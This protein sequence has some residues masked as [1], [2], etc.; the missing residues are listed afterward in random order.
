MDYERGLR[1]LHQAGLPREEQELLGSTETTRA[2]RQQI[3]LGLNGLART[4]LNTSFLKLSDPTIR[5]DYAPNLAQ[6][7]PPSEHFVG[8]REELERLVAALSQPAREG[9][10]R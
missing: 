10:Q 3:M 6:L 7:R 1:A 9:A 5:E 8:R 2:E 4:Y